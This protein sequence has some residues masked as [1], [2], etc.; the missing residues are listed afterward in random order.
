MKFLNK[1]KNKNKNHGI[2]HDSPLVKLDQLRITNS[3]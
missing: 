2:I 3:H 1:S